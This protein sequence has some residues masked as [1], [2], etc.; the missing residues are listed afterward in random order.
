M[1]SE[2][3]EAWE[4]FHNA[5]P[6]VYKGLVN[7]A[8]Y[9]QSQ[10]K[11]KIGIDLLWGRLR[12]DIWMATKRETGDFKLNNNF[13]SLYARMIMRKEADLRDIFNLRRLTHK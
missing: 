13:R 3:L 12:W 10:G 6:H 9:A 8:R 2:T 5:N 7:L 4:R 1:T 11:R